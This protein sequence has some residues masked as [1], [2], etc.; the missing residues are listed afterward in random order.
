M[1]TKE[2]KELCWN[3]IIKA[4]KNEAVNKCRNCSRKNKMFMVEEYNY[5]N[6]LVGLILNEMRWKVK[7]NKDKYAVDL[8]GVDPNGNEIVCEA[9]VEFY[10]SNNVFFETHDKGIIKDYWN[11]SKNKQTYLGAVC[12]KK[13]K[14]H[15]FDISAFREYQAT[16]QKFRLVDSHYETSGFLFDKDTPYPFKVGVYDLGI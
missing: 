5:N 7:L 16:K 4:S 3:R 13:M 12:P 8:L 15:L 14:L 2:K 9:K 10:P 11:N 6:I 1:T